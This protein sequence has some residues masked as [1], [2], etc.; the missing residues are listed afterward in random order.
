[1][2]KWGK[3]DKRHA[4]ECKHATLINM[5]ETILWFRLDFTVF[6]GIYNVTYLKILNDVTI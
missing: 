1:M 4:I 3:G 5:E 2:G 6:N